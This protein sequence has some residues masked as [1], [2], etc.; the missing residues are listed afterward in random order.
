MNLLAQCYFHIFR[1]RAEGC[2]GRGGAGGWKATAVS[3]S[4]CW[5]TQPFLALLNVFAGKCL[6]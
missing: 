5:K 2:Q 6:I 4:P 1:G 3:G